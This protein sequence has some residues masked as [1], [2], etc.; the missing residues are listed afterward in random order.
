MDVKSKQLSRSCNV[1]FD[2][3]KFYAGVIREN[4]KRDK[5]ESSETEQSE[6]EDFLEPQ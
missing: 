1:N 5:I 4:M 2:E 3:M 6:I